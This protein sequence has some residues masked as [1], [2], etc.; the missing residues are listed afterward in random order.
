MAEA[1]DALE[2]VERLGDRLAQDDAGVLDRVMHVDVKVALGLDLHVDAAVASKA[3]QHVVV[4]ADAG[5]DLGRAGPVQIHAH[6]NLRLLGVADDLRLAIHRQ[7]PLAAARSFSET[8][9]RGP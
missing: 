7:Y 8:C 6:A 3:L 2:A 9:G 4:E 1:A 5:R